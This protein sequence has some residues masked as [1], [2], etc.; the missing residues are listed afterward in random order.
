MRPVAL[1]EKVS[2]KS[3]EDADLALAELSWLDN[4]RA[5]VAAAIKQQVDAIK[6]ASAKKEILIID[7]TETT[8]GDRAKYLHDLLTPWVLKNAKAHVPEKKKSVDLPHG[9]I[10][11]RQQPL[12]VAFADG[13]NEMAVLDAI[14]AQADGIVGT[15][16]AW[17]I[18]RLKNLASL[19]VKDVLT[20]G[21][22]VNLKGVKDAL[23][24][25]RITREQVESLG[26]AIR[27]P[28]D[29]AVIKPAKTVVVIE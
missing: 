5:K 4:E 9:T 6:T 12:V 14:D 24:D 8:L 16:R 29:D 7:N 18:K 17:A 1:G 23:E 28:Y 22:I 26:L 13:V 21:V 19:F 11:L 20:I 27:D 25:G 15:I 10:G 2:I 3:I